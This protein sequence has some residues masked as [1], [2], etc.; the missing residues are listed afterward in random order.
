MPY[1]P[2]T[3]NVDLFLEK[4]E[5]ICLELRSRQRCEIN[6]FV[7]MNLDLKKVRDPRIKGITIVLREWASLSACMK[8][9]M[10]VEVHFHHWIAWRP[11]MQNFTIT[12]VFSLF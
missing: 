6:L 7:D 12:R 9:L 5:H 4:L 10:L 11:Q 1:R 3:G 2:P 8:Q